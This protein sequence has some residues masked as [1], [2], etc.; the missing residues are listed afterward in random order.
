M[1]D[2]RSSCSQH[3]QL[4]EW[5]K[6]ISESIAG[7]EAYIKTS[8]KNQDDLFDRLRE[9]QSTLD[10]RVNLPIQIEHLSEIAE[11]NKKQINTL[12][13][14]VSNGLTGRTKNIEITVDQLKESLT[15]LQRHNDVEDIRTELGV[16]GYLASSW[17]EFKKLSGPILIGI[18][19][20]LL[21]WGF[22]KSVVYKEYPFVVPIAKEIT[23]NSGGQTN[24]QNG[25]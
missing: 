4:M 6:T 13:N 8:L 16:Q 19:I 10:K 15:T 22:I 7:H 11:D 1:I 3:P 9:L 24:V 18:V 14:I 25:R 20:W 5:I 2:E 21:T 23:L 12:T 17:K